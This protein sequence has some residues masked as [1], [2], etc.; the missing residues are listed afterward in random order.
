MLVVEDEFLIALDIQRVLESVGVKTVVTASRV[1]QALDLVMSSGPFDAAVLD[2]KLER[3]SSAPVA[4]RLRD[5]G[6]PFIFLTGGSM[7]DE[8]RRFPDVPVI[9]KPFDSD[10]LLAAL[11]K[12]MVPKH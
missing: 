10:G 3:D 5:S 2:L 1:A 6:V 11:A 7:S 9:G 12:V 4:E 8:T